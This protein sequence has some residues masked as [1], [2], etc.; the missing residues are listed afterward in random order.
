MFEQVFCSHCRIS[1]PKSEMR[2]V[3]TKN[4]KRWRC[5]KSIEAATGTEAERNAFGK[6]VRAKNRA[7]AQSRS[8]IMNAA[9]SISA[10]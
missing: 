3:E 10:R 4:G 9:K 6:A 5:I 7:E 1:H 8:R 2:L